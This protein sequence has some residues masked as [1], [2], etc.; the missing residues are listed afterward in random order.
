MKTARTYEELKTRLDEMSGKAA[1]KQ[2]D[3]HYKPG[4]S[5]NLLSGEDYL[6][7]IP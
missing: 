6:K 5:Y 3:V 7:Y 2:A 4:V 1:E